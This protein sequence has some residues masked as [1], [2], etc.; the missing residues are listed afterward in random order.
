MALPKSDSMA[1]MSKTKLIE[2][3]IFLTKLQ[4]FVFF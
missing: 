4:N 2:A 3:N 1:A